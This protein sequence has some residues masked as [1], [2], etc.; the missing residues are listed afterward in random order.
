MINEVCGYVYPAS[1]VVKDM[2]VDSETP[3]VTLSI[4]RFAGLYLMGISENT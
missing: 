4:S 2:S 3:M 1:S